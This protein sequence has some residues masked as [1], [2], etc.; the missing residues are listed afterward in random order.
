TQ[1]RLKLDMTRADGPTAHLSADLGFSLDQFNV[2]GQIA[3]EESTKG[4]VVAYLLGRPD[5]EKV[6]LKLAIKGDRESGAGE[7][8]TTAG[9]ALTSNGNA[10]WQ[11]DGPATGISV[12]LNLAGPGLPEGP[13]G[14][15]LR[16][17]ATLTGEATLD[18]K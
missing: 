18:D 10:R 6:T 16:S 12:N 17:P 1:S 3:A 14:R 13:I 4:G 15:L 5:L 9:D 8:T 11:R 7:F 2:D